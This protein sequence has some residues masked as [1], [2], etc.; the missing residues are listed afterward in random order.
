MSNEI[1]IVLWAYEEKESIELAKIISNSEINNE[2]FCETNYSD[3]SVKIYPRYHGL[4]HKS[5]PKELTDIIVLK[6]TENTIGLAKEYIDTRKGIMFRFV[7]GVES[8][9]LEAEFIEDI[10]LN[11]EKIFKSAVDHDKALKEVFN[12][13]DTNKNGMLDRDEIIKVSQ[14][15]SHCLNESDANEIIAVLGEEG[16]IN[17]NQFKHWWQ[18]GRADLVGFREVVSLIMKLSNFF[19]QNLEYFHKHVDLLSKDF[20]SNESSTSCK[21]SFLPDKSEFRE[22][23]KTSINLHCLLGEEYEKVKTTFPLYYNEAFTFGIELPL[24][25]N[26]GLEFDEVCTRLAEITK[27]LTN[28][29]PNLKTLQS[30]GL[31][32]NCRHQGEIYIVEF[33]IGG[34][35][36]DMLTHMSS[37]FNLDKLNYNGFVDGHFSSKI[38]LKDFL[39]QEYQEKSTLKEIIREMLKLNFE[40]VQSFSKLG[41]LI[42]LIIT[43]LKATVFAEKGIPTALSNLLTTI[44]FYLAIRNLNFKIEYDVDEILANLVNLFPNFFDK[45]PSEIFDITQVRNAIQFMKMNEQIA[46]LLK[47]INL[48]RFNFFFSTPLIK[49]FVKISLITL[50][51]NQ[52]IDEI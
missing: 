34:H 12:K 37:K 15:L 51:L 50:E 40:C 43:V 46:S 8:K 47:I 3:Y 39:S 1:N 24:A 22:F 26:S 21:Y 11:K 49:K 38:S 32:L 9:S 14:E 28:L 29:I 44:K 33:S 7:I 48:D 30:Q 5:A 27:E 42:D 36:G 13:I 45:K 25:K 35:V 52:A 16:K 18:L 6:V 19:N 17:Y 10:T 23:H 31:Q 41:N 20:V 4:I 2:G